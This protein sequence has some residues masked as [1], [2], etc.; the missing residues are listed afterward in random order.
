MQ[1]R[2][3]K[4]E[5]QGVK[6]WRDHEPP[7]RQRPTHFRARVYFASGG[8]VIDETANVHTGGSVKSDRYILRRSHGRL[9]LVVRLDDES[10]MQTLIA[11]LRGIDCR[12][13]SQLRL[14]STRPHARAHPPLA[15]GRA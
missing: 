8:A 10:V 12:S 11:R 1:K 6:K 5:M 2:G 14:F 9:E 13:L 3:S 15:G 7:L 4:Y